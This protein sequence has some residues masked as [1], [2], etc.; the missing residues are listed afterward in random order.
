MRSSARSPAITNT[1]AVP[2]TVRTAAAG[3][4][5]PGVAPASSM[6]AVAKNPGF[7]RPSGL[8]TTASRVSARVAASTD[9]DT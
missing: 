1:R 5:M 9:G 3:T 4:T 2:A 6:R 8:G 7:S